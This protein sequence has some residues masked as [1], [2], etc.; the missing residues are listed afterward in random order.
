MTLYLSRMSLN[1]FAPTR[2]LA[3][4]LNPTDAS[5]AADA[6]HKLIWTLFGDAQDRDRDFLWRYDGQGRFFTL[7]RRPPLQNELFSDFACKEFAPNLAVGDRLSFVL[8]ANA[9]RERRD[10]AAG[11]TKRSTRV[12]VVMDLMHQQGSVDR[13]ED[14][15]TAAQQAA[16]DWLSRQSQGAGFELLSVT[17]HDYSTLHLG[18]QGRERHRKFGV[19]D[20]SGTISIT[21][22]EAFAARYVQGFGRAKAWGCGFMMIRRKS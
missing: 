14:R 3:S 17:T 13:G 1:R 7:S 19:L 8:R 15:Q 4:L 22:P 5:D 2:A 20:L 6:H 9:T 11:R 21:D 18:G 10:P 16:T 12:D